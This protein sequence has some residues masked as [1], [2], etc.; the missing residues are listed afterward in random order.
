MRGAS[1][2]CSPSDALG[3]QMDGGCRSHN[4]SGKYAKDEVKMPKAGP[5]RLLVVIYWEQVP[6]QGGQNTKICIRNFWDV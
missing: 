1:L 2:R 4:L 5:P 6:K 3:C